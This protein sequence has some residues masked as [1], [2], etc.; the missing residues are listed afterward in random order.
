M[1][2]LPPVGWLIS[3]GGSG[4]DEWMAHQWDNRQAAMKRVTHAK[5]TLAFALRAMRGLHLPTPPVGNDVLTRDAW[6]AIMD[7]LRQSR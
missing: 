7:R 6:I 2:R 1:A 3:V 4:P 5:A